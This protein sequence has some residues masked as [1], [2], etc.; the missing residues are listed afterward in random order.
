MNL[1]IDI[2]IPTLRPLAELRNQIADI[3]RTAVLPHTVIA[4]CQQAS[5][6]VN[7]NFGLDRASSDVVITLDDDVTGFFPGWDLRLVMPLAVNPDLVMV[8]ARLMNPDGSPG[9][10]CADN[11]DLGPDLIYIR[12]RP[13]LPAPLMPSAAIAFRNIGLRYDSNYEGSGW[14]DGDF[15]AEISRSNRNF[16]YVISNQCRLIHWNEMKNQ[17]GKVWERNERYFRLKWGF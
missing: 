3:E 15:M 14:E 13:D 11:Y 2:I 16:R 9:P 10:N 1:P 4:T 8:S 12:K 6:A 17:H 5:A 7:R